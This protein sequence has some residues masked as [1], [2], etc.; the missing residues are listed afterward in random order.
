MNPNQY[1][2][3]WPDMVP[4][5]EAAL[6]RHQEAVAQMADFKKKYASVKNKAKRTQQFLM[7]LDEENRKWYELGIRG[8]V[9]LAENKL[10]LISKKLRGFKQHEERSF[11]TSLKALK[12][13][14]A[15]NPNS[16]Q[17]HIQ[18]ISGHA[19]KVNWLLHEVADMLRIAKGHL[20]KA[21]SHKKFVTQV[22]KRT[23]ST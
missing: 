10:A 23:K 16:T 19:Q 17:W 12:G 2:N 9:R 18:Q 13:S 22:R 6:L 20:D 7:S 14:I 3:V 1:P 15:M 21:T 4:A 11:R 8:N 5:L